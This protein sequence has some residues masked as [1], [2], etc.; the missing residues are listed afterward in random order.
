[1]IKLKE[2]GHWFIAI[3]EGSFDYSDCGIKVQGVNGVN[4]TDLILFLSYLKKN[5]VCN[6]RAHGKFNTPKQSKQ[7]KQF[8]NKM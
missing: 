7:F 6:K 1:M 8:G 4:V 2:Q 5:G 3:D